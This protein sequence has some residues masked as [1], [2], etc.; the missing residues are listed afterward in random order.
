MQDLLHVEPW[1]TK[2]R[3]AADLST[4]RLPP[5]PLVVL[6]QQQQTQEE[7][8]GADQLFLQ[9][10]LESIVMPRIY[11]IVSPIITEV[12]ERR[13]EYWKQ[14]C[15]EAEKQLQEVLRQTKYSSCPNENNFTAT[16]VPRR[17]KHKRANTQAIVASAA[18]SA[19]K[20]RRKLATASENTVISQIVQ[21]SESPLNIEKS[22]AVKASS[23]GSVSSPTKV[24][25]PSYH[26]QKLLSSRQFPPKSAPQP[27]TYKYVEVVR[28][29]AE[30]R[31]LIGHTCPECDAFAKFV[32]QARDSHGNLI[33]DSK[34]IVQTCSRHRNQFSQGESNTPED[35]WELSFV[36]SIERRRKKA[37][38]YETKLLGENLKLSFDS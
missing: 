6:Q 17:G 28:N 13:V 19:A 3:T 20:R 8:G 31:S 36:D 18:A 16:V 32:L 27:E 4:K 2:M 38:Q 37:N 29:R 11:N 21:H 5:S 23:D 24:T 34:D 7:D 33:Y 10:A 1:Q 15:I 26:P 9:E 35:F 12:V 25:T 14:K 30:R 22:T